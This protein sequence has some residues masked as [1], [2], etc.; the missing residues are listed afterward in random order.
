L[1]VPTRSM[2]GTER[3]ELRPGG[4]ECVAIESGPGQK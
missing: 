4:D 2:T 3:P 1:R